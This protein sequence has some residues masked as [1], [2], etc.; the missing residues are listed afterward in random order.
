[1]STL[2]FRGNTQIEHL[3]SNDRG[4]AYGDGLF[5][6]ILVHRGEFVWWSQHWRRLSMDA[7]RLGI[8]L[9]D[10]AGIFSAVQRLVGQQTCVLKIIVTRGESG[11]GY[12]MATGP[13]TT[14]MSIHPVPERHA[15]PIALRWCQTPIAQQPALAGIKHLN[16]LENIL[17]RSEWCSSDYADGLMCDNKG[18]VI[19]AT[20]ANIFIYQAA[21]WRTP[22]LALCGI[23]GIARQWFLAQMPDCMVTTLSR[24]VVE[25]AEAIF[26]CN[27]VRGMMVVKC[28]ETIQLPSN[29][30]CAEWQQK[31]LAHNPAFNIE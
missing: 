8:T 31:F 13:T 18:S 7:A 29:D 1:M 24:A 10:E 17:A 26:L 19:C 23:D 27:S 2:I 14:V 21:R 5:E 22:S 9:P 12:A 30:L 20:S 28:I 4:F 3:S 25:N 15:L 16:R 6:S 11:R